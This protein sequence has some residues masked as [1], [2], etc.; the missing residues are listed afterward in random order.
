MFFAVTLQGKA[1]DERLR[2]GLDRERPGR[3][4]DRIVVP[5]QSDDRDAEP[6]G[7]GPGQFRYVVG[8]IPLIESLVLLEDL[9]QEP[10]DGRAHARWLRRFRDWFSRPNIDGRSHSNPPNFC[11]L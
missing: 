8:Y 7:I 11:L 2:D 9:Q 10:L 5:I 3:I 4:A 6:P 1:V